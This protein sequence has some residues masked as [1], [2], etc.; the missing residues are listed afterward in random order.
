[1]E[2]LKSI[3]TIRLF[4]QKK[5]LAVKKIGLVPTM[6]ALHD[7][8]LELVKFSKGQNDLTIVSIFV[9]PMQFNKKEDFEKYPNKVSED[10]KTLEEIGCDVIFMPDSREMYTENETLKFN[11]GYIERLMEGEFRP[12][13]FSGVGLV[14]S[15]LFNIVNPDRA[16]FG[17]KDLQQLTII[18]KLAKDLNFNVEIIGVPTVRE[19]SGLAM[20]SRNLRLSELEKEIAINVYKSLR[21]FQD[22]LG[23]NNSIVQSKNQVID[24]LKSI[25]GLE[26]EYLEIV[27]THSLMPIMEIIK[28][29]SFS[30]CIAVYVSKIRLIDNITI[31]N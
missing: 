21:L 11:F 16:Y 7:G 4:I 22:L 20:S 2:I 24:F 15:K 9:N 19:A 12:G 14:I 8:H 1:M 26:L 13:H 5:R 30:L 28:N 18:K 25:K 10:I 31:I 23:A 29:R 6:G 27:D 3:D 17:E